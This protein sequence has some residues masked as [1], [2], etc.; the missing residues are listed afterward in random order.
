MLP[1]SRGRWQGALARKRRFR[2]FW[3]RR[4]AG[5]VPS[6]NNCGFGGGINEGR[7]TGAIPRPGIRD[8]AFVRHGIFGTRAGG[9]FWRGQKGSLHGA[10]SLERLRSRLFAFRLRADTACRLPGRFAGVGVGECF[11]ECWV[12]V[13]PFLGPGAIAI[14]ASVATATALR[15]G[16]VF[17]L[18][19][20][21]PRLFLD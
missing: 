18:V 4:R 19:A 13:A 11:K 14:A 1:P 15:P 20:L 7:F 8:G 10:F 16:N 12:R 6:E 3:L 2:M 21:S 17:F 5:V 9:F